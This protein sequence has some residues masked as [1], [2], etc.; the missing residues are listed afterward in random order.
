MLN[1][2]QKHYQCYP[3]PRYPL[4]ASV[5]RC[6]TYALNLQALWSRFNRRLPPPD[7]NRILLAGCGTFSPYPFSVANPDASI[8]ALDLSR[9]SLDR[10]RLHCLLHGCRNI[11]YRCGDI[12]DGKSVEG[13]FGLIDSYGVLHHLDDPLEGLKTLEKHLLPNGIIRIMLYSRYARKEEEAIRR[14]LRLLGITTPAAARKL[15]KKARPGSRLANYL[16]VA[17]EPRTDFGMADALLHP[18]VRT[19]RI[20]ELLEMIAQAGLQPLLFAHV[21][22]RENVLEEIERIRQLEKERCSPGNFV[23]Y[24]GSSAAANPPEYASSSLIRLN[25]CLTNSVSRFTLNTVHIPPRIGCSNTALQSAER[26]LLRQFLSPLHSSELSGEL[27]GK[28][29]NFKRQLF[30]TEYN[31]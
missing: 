3:Y 13:T 16:D 8:T 9:S 19:Y 27:A 12:L 23:L 14:A 29:D 17:D 21:G 7:A 24:L 26:R 15:L 2:V 18:R 4:L 6:D 5:R 11:T 10:A 20:E 22:A 28:V 25:P 31:P 1:P 30:L